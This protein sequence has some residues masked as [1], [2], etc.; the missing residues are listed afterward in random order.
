MILCSTLF[1][2]QQVDPFYR[3]VLEK[4]EQLYMEGDYKNAIKKLNV[5]VFGL[6]NASEL[7]AKAYV[8][9]CLSHLYLKDADKS[10]MY[11]R[12]AEKLMDVEALLSLDIAD[13]ARNDLERFIYTIKAGS[14]PVGGLRMLPKL[15]EEITISNPVSDQRQMEQS[16]RENPRNPSS[17][18]AL[19]N[20]QRENYDYEGGKKTI[21]DLVDKMPSEM[22]GH[23]LLGIID[24]QEKKYDD[25]LDRFRDFYRLSAEVALKEKIFTEVISYQIL[26]NYLKG[27]RDKAREIITQNISSLTLEKIRALP[28]SER[29]KRMVLGIINTYP[30]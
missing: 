19:Y 25:A 16:I 14:N 23:Y 9:L 18:Y 5:A 30:K 21:E 8:Y 15:P 6:N 7:Q 17:Y 20:I 24:Y 26:S 3:N 1:G 12:E 29:D 28:L 22:Y 10:E 2:R 4:G 27:D 11:L 13:G